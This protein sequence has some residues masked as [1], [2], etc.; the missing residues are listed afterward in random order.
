M[1]LK[2][3]L[4]VPP[5]MF[6][7][8]A[9]SVNFVPVGKGRLGTNIVSP[10]GNLIPIVRTTTQYPNPANR[11]QS[12]H[13]ELV[14]LIGQ[15]CQHQINTN[16]FKLN[17]G[18]CEI[19]TDQ[20]R[21]MGW[22]T[23]QALDLAPNT[24]I[25]ICSFYEN[26]NCKNLRKL[27]IQ[28]KTTK[29]QTEIT[30]EPNSLVMFSYDTNCQHVHRIILPNEEPSS[31]WLGITFR[32]SKTFIDFTDGEPKIA[33]TNKLLHLASH[34]EKSQMIKLKGIE[35]CSVDFTYPELDYTISPSDLISPI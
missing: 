24:W 2:Y 20:Y 27:Q 18:L 31:P 35:N 1:F 12:I 30:L 5:N 26:P 15:T 3:Q 16:D 13:L 23:D 25:C 17:N 7:E 29:N 6:E 14:E 8:L 10:S 22:H 9:D 33:N 19:Y 4:L 28:N 34:E 11:F 32:C 21:K